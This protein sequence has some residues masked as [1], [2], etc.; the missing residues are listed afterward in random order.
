MY[1]F[2]LSG[3]LTIETTPTALD[4]RCTAINFY[5]NLTHCTNRQQHIEKNN[6]SSGKKR[7]DQT[8]VSVVIGSF[9][10]KPLPLLNLLPGFLRLAQLGERL[11]A[12]VLGQ[13]LLQRPD[14]RVVVRGA[15]GELEQRRRL[16]RQRP[17]DQLVVGA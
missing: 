8:S 15:G 17:R 10:I 13:R 2:Q 6:V 9:L 16:P 3:K 7:N 5:F 12:V 14:R 1:L 4:D 11:L